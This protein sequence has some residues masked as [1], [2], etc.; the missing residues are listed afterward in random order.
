[1]LVVTVSK[2]YKQ[3]KQPV[4]IFPSSVLVKQKQPCVFR[5]DA[6]NMLLYISY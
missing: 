4:I 3:E 5:R 2:L 6:V 1:V